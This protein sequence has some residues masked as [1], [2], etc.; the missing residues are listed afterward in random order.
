M[1]EKRRLLLKGLL[2]ITTMATAM[3][4]MPRLAM[5]KWSK[6]FDSSSVCLL[7]TSDAADE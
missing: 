7:Y 5:A 1:R 4:A 3:T 2:G 6:A